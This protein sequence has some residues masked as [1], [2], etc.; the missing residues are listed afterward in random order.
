MFKKN[1][2]IVFFLL[3]TSCGYEAIYSKKNAENYDFSIS[4]INLEGDRDVNL[5]IK[6]TLNNYV[7]SENNKK[8]DLDIITINEK[9][10]IAKDTAGDPTDF[11]NTTTVNVEVFIGGK[12]HKKIVI[13]ENFKYKN[14]TNKFNLKTNETNLKINLAETIAEELIFRLSNI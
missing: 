2:L 9:T 13:K 12:F 5:R 1:I 11:E 4:S 6:Q 14:I 8:F 10:I 3:T 7:S